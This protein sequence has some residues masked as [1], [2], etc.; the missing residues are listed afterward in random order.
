LFL[1]L[2]GLAVYAAVAAPKPPQGP[3]GGQRVTHNRGTAA[4]FAGR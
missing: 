4:T 1:L 2:L 3:S